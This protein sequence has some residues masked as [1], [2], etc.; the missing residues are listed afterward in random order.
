MMQQS[1]LPSKELL[2]FKLVATT[3][4]TVKGDCL[5]CTRE[6]EP[7]AK[8]V[9]RHVCFLPKTQKT[10][11]QIPEQSAPNFEPLPPNITEAWAQALLAQ[12]SLVKTV[13][14]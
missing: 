10:I 5:G 13:T 4:R 9:W 1:G 6:L 8:V 11:G 3:Q 12:D 14:P 7:V 2:G